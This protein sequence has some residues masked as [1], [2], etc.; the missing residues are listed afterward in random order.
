VGLD[1]IRSSAEQVPGL[2]TRAEL[3]Q[4]LDEHDRIEKETEIIDSGELKK[5]R[6]FTKG[7]SVRERF[8]RHLR[9]S[10]SPKRLLNG[11]YPPRTLT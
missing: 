2:P 6:M 5:L 4:F 1:A 7:L 10:L 9:T 8:L 11:T 3:Q